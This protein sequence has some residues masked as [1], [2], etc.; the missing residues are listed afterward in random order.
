MT[1]TENAP[2]EVTDAGFDE[3]VLKADGISVVDFWAPWCGPCHT[4]APALE[5]FAAQ[6]AGRVKVFK[7]NVDDNPKIAE[8]YQIRSIPTILFLRD[9][10]KADVNVGA[11]S[12]SSLQ[13]KFDSLLGG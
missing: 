1:M 12:Q 8:R 3:K 11:M 10:Y 7:L 5:A 9:G 4:M 2:V 13:S 6:N